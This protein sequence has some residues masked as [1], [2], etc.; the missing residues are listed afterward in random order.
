MSGV[1]GLVI[2]FEGCGLS[3]KR[4]VRLTIGVCFI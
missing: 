3:D 2:K 4:T 1:V